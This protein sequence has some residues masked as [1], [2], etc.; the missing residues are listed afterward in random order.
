MPFHLGKI[1]D[2]RAA[3]P[4]LELLQ[5]DEYEK[6]RVCAAT[7]LRQ[8]KEPEVA[9]ALIDALRHDKE[10]AVRH[11]AA[12]ALGGFKNNSDV[13]TA[14]LEALSQEAVD[15]RWYAVK[16]LGEIGDERAIPELER[17]RITDFAVVGENLTISGR[18]AK[19]LDQIRERH[20]LPAN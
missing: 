18:A 12:N 8:F 3:T 15:V 5:R 9:K 17:L 11:S 1:G 19:A 4:F 16:S 13:V 10:E 7:F 2:K 20:N 14:L 6:V